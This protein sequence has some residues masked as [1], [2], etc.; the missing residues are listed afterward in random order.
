MVVASGSSNVLRRLRL[1]EC[2][3]SL[4]SKLQNGSYFFVFVYFYLSKQTHTSARHHN[5]I[6]QTDTFLL[7]CYGLSHFAF[8]M[9]HDGRSGGGDGSPVMTKKKCH[10]KSAIKKAPW[11]EAIIVFANSYDTNAIFGFRRIN[12]KLQTK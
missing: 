2:K 6:C 11:P 9:C 10:K 12:L 5:V 8:G 4:S 7:H 1:V 3:V